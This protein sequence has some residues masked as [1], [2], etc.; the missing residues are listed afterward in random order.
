LYRQGVE[1]LTAQNRQRALDL[2]AAAWKKEAELDPQM[3]MQLKDKLTVLTQQQHTEQVAPQEM[4]P[5]VQALSQEQALL[6]QRMFREVTTEIAESERMVNDQPVQALERLK[7][8]RLRVSQSNI[9]GGS[10]KEY[11]AMVDRVI[12]HVDAYIKQ[13]EAAINQQLRNTQIEQDIVNDAANQAKLGA[14]LQKL[15]DEFNDLN[16]QERYP[17]AEIVAKKVSELSP[18]SELAVVMLDK[19]RAA[20]R[21]YD[22]KH[23]Q[24]LKAEGFLDFMNSTELAAV[25]MDPDKPLQMPSSEELRVALAR[26]K[27]FDY[28]LSPNERVI[29]E[30]LLDSVSVSFQGRPLAYAVET[31]TQMTGIPI[32]I[33]PVGLAAEGLTD[34][35]P[36]SLELNGNSI[37][38]KSALNILLEPLNLTYIVKDEV[39][40]VT[41]RR[42]VRK[43][44]KKAVYPVGDLVIPIP[45]FSAG[46]SSPFASALES[47]YQTQAGFAMV[48]NQSTTTGSQFGAAQLAGMQGMDPN[49]G[50]LGQAMPGGM[51][52]PLPG[53]PVGGMGMMNG[54]FGTGA[55]GGGG[56]AG[57]GSQANF[58]TLID[59]I[60]ATIPGEWES[61]EETITPFASNLSLVINAPLDTHE[62]IQ[63]LLKQLRAL[64]NL[65][66][67]IEIRFITLSDNFY[68]RMGI[69]FDFN[70]D[71]NNGRPGVNPN[72]DQGPS[73]AIGLS[74]GVSN[75]GPVGTATSD[76]DL[77]FRQNSFATTTPSLPGAAFTPDPGAQLGFAILSDIEMFFFL[78]AVQ[79]DSRTN[80]MQA[81]KVTM[82]DGQSASVIDGAQVPFVTGLTPVV[83]DFAVAQQPIIA[84]LHEGT[85][86]TVQ[87][88]V[89][90]DK[91]FV[92]MTMSPTF[93]TITNRD[94]TFTFTGSTSSNTGTTVI[95]EDG[96]PLPDNDNAQTNFVGSTVQLPTLGVTTI[97][98]TVVVPDGGTILLGG[99]KR[100]SETRQEQGVPMLSK[101][102]YVNRLFSN[103]GTARTANT[104]MM[105]VTPRIIIPEEE[106]AAV[107]GTAPVTP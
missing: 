15:V 11:L 61:E 103:I 17:E 44:M 39:L 56:G 74:G 24:G 83:G 91:R 42:T 70:V 84:I 10:R 64:Q 23:V 47:A 99:I 18:G 62:Q 102:P 36:V 2:F 26:A 107:L 34:Q 96:T 72:D 77:Q 97:S 100:L 73:T 69:D 14:E 49:A 3:R 32:I 60:Q 53:V 8:L 106:E 52:S 5:G 75:F 45:N 41:S 40:K 6:R 82:F 68:E 30:K 55:M 63:A 78:N 1:A 9:E 46:N 7:A 76:L 66:V 101:I 85:Q 28:G 80:V 38:L 27:E 33:D 89:T 105:T 35:Q 25:P 31:I 37:S 43:E 86:L 57:G 4:P 51:G 98:T 58:N 92:R 67:T 90:P 104:F 79:S 95:G 50:A 13:N 21:I 59:L 94:R 29:R 88:V 16:R 22:A 19:A 48:R 93:S 54:G 87:S 12:N 65:Q 71:D 20:R 81:P